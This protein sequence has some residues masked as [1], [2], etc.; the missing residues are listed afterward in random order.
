MKSK[1]L[2]LLTLTKCN[3]TNLNLIDFFL[4]ITNNILKLLKKGVNMSDK[5]INCRDCGNEF[6]WTTDQQKFFKSKKIKK[7]PVRCRE[8]AIKIFEEKKA[9][10]KQPEQAVQTPENSNN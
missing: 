7:E 10:Q 1:T 4:I 8:C 6:T 5:N 2:K 9:Q 3:G